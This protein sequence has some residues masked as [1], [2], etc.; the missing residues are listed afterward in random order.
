MIFYILILW[1]VYMTISVI[2]TK[3]I[4][5]KFVVIKYL[6]QKF[7][8]FFHKFM[9]FKCKYFENV[10]FHERASNFWR[11]WVFF[12]LNSTVHR[13]EGPDASSRYHRNLPP[14][15]PSSDLTRFYR[16]SFLSEIAKLI[17]LAWCLR[18]SEAICAHLR[19]WIVNCSLTWT[20]RDRLRERGRD[21]E[22][23]EVLLQPIQSGGASEPCMRYIFYTL[24]HSFL[25]LEVVKDLSCAI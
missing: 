19:N 10:F 4:F 23:G 20:S 14:L 6:I 1:Q 24:R 15:L 7:N 16:Q 3:F 9:I 12:T 11:L 5:W 21:I 18:E 25:E 8:F 22:K 13:R 17:P 2:S